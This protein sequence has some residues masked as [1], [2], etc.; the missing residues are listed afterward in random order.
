MAIITRARKARKATAISQ[1]AEEASV[2]GEAINYF[3]AAAA[4][5]DLNPNVTRIL[6]HPSRQV[7]IS[8][9]FQLDNGDLEVFTGYR[10]QYSFARGPAKGGVRYHPG[11]SLDE[12]TALAFWMTW[13]CAVVDLPFGGAKGGVTCDP[14]KLSVNELERLTRRYAAE[15][16][17]IIGPDKDVPAPDVGTNPQT[18]AWIMDTVSMHHRAHTPGVVTG[19]PLCIG[20]SRGRVEATGRG[21]TIAIEAA[22]EKMGKSLAG[23]T[24]VVQGF[25]NVGSIT[26]KLLAE[27]G[28]KIVGIG[29]QFTGLSNKGGIDITAAIAHL[30][31]TTNKRRSL[32]GLAGSEQTTNSDLLELPCDILVPAALE[33]Q[34]TQDNAANI[35]AYLI[36][37]GANG[38][39]TP[40]ADRML[41]EGGV[42][43]I[44]DI[45]AN[46]G[47]VTVSY[48]EWAQD[49]MGYYWRESEVNDKLRDVL[50]ENFDA[51]WE[52]ARS[53]K[54]SLRTAAYMVAIRRV[55]DSLT[56]RGIYA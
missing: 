45:L 16:I 21:V 17:E 51:V 42:T 11:V 7:I 9:P 48:F 29:D 20:G 15:I 25:G 23:A 46:A 32:E 24:V 41:T 4:S 43:I 12:V 10:V 33:D 18:M 36:A 34:L 47:G 22:L 26:A 56:T 30:S 50:R 14:T 52:T 19:K 1:Q 13:K 39:T 49:R 31:A 28:A 44:P 37:E 27:R 35:K 38:P 8:I 6:K 54:T 40:A 5:L 55:I 2:F 3:D 53:H